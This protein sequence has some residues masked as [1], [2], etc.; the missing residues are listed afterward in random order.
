VALGRGLK[1]ALPFLLGGGA[2]VELLFKEMMTLLQKF[3]PGAYCV[4]NKCLGSFVVRLSRDFS[5]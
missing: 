1:I 5:P 4:F 2:G 3:E